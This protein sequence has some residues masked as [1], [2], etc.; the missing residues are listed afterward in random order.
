MRDL[1]QKKKKSFLWDKVGNTNVVPISVKILFIF[2]LFILVSNFTTNYINLVF[3]QTELINQMRE[4]LS[5][6]LKEIYSYASNQHE[7]Y[8]FTQDR[9]KSLKGIEKKAQ[10]ELDGKR[11][12]LLG[13]KENGEL[14]FQ[15]SPWK[16]WQNFGDDKVLNK[17][18]QLK[19]EDKEDGFVNFKLD[20]YDYFGVYKY[21]H[22]WD[23]YML[24]G[25]ELNEFYS[26][27]RTIF[28]DV[29]II[30]VIATII[31][32]VVGIF[33]LRYILRYIGIISK[34]IMHMVEQQRMDVV[35]LHKAPNDDIT[36]L[37]M[38][39]NSLSSSISNL[40][41]IFR[42]FANKDVVLKA[43]RDHEVNL[44]GES[45][46]LAILFTDIRSFTFITET[47]GMDIIRLLNMHYDRAI[48]EILKY[49][50]VIGAIIGDALLAV[51]GVLEETSYT[52][53]SYSA[54]LGAY[55]VQDVA[56]SL[57]QQ[58]KK[59]KE[60]IESNRGELTEEESRM[61]QAVLLEVG[62]GLDGGDV[63]YGT[64]GSYERMTNTVIGDNVNSAARL[65][66]LTRVYEAP[67]ICSEFIKKEVEDNVSDSGIHFIELD[68]VQVKGKTIGKKIYWPV[69]DN[70]YQLM[71]DDLESFR[72]GLDLYYRGD[73]PKAYKEFEKCKLPVAKV[74]RERTGNYTC[75]ENWNGIWEMKTK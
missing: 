40:L 45:K 57:R 39:F 59:K 58:M 4:I 32:A 33:V 55:S 19:K 36:F 8:K 44:E 68:T 2:T 42:K 72:K 37:G 60:E 17:M 69:L 1:V 23:V 25:E 22:K 71:Q 29:S 9:E 28:R 52:N 65:E 43:Y 53:K 12:V 13:I 10:H 49:N 61:Y 56:E 3:N 15:A 63:F 7:I 62:V 48:R 18:I 47:L 75:P 41:S 31:I 46:E 6:E 51:Y 35:D 26:K 70:D 64:L 73:W 21:N 5:K 11:S 20:G 38:A 30:I 16:E 66:G 54:I 67:V 27:S 34:E 50:G 14:L 74:F 24:R